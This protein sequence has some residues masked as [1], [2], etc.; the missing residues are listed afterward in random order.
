MN[1]FFENNLLMHLKESENKKVVR[2]LH[3][4]ITGLCSPVQ[5]ASNAV[6]YR[7]AENPLTISKVYEKE[8]FT[9]ENIYYTFIHPSPPRLKYDYEQS[10]YDKLKTKYASRW[11]GMFLGSQF[12]VHARKNG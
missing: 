7:S 10:V 6:L 11:E 4:N 5:K 12:L 2:D 9:V 8:G 3:L 1:D